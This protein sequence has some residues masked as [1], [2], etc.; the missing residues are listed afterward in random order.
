MIPNSIARIGGSNI[1]HHHSHWYGTYGTNPYPY[2]HPYYDFPPPLAHTYHYPTSTF[3]YTQYTRMY[4]PLSQN[5]VHEYIS[6]SK[7][8]DFE[9]SPRKNTIYPWLKNDIELKDAKTCN[10]K[11][12]TYLLC[13]AVDLRYKTFSHKQQLEL[14]E[15]I[16]RRESFLAGYSKPIISSTHFHK[17]WI[18][19]QDEIR[20]NTGN[21]TYV[22]HSKRT[23]EE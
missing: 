9:M 10:D 2:R 1:D 14:G 11:F 22:I 23:K 12:K 5:N 4:T 8:L 7:E 19:F 6:K 3:D 16:I 18:L 20:T 21:A 13:Q 15:A 17:L